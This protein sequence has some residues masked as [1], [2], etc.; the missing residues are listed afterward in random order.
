MFTSGRSVKAILAGVVLAAIVATPAAAAV[1]M[2]SAI[3]ARATVTV[4]VQDPTHHDNTV[5]N[6]TIR[7]W[8]ATHP[9]TPQC[10]SRQL[11]PHVGI[12]ELGHPG[13]P[14]TALVFM[15]NVGPKCRIGGY[16]NI[17]AWYGHRVG[18]TATHVAGPP[19]SFVL[20]SGA[21]AHAQL[22]STGTDKFAPRECRPT[23]TNQLRLVLP[24]TR[25][26]MYVGFII[27]TCAGRSVTNLYTRTIQKGTGLAV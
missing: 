19:S 4:P 3:S 13:G 6:Q 11:R 18:N 2:S 22:R 15:Q 7:E 20:A 1:H 24:G 14:E 25:P 9:A 27:K 23:Q 26:A 8:N 21:W 16:L 10:Q 12:T 5:I 17:T